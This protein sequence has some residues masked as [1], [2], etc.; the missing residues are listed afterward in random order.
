MIQQ[1][2]LKCLLAVGFMTAAMLSAFGADNA[3]DEAVKKDRKRIEGTWKVVSFTINGN[4]S[5]GDIGKIIVVNGADGSWNLTV[6][7]QELGQGATTINP[8]KKPKEIDI[9]PTTGDDKGKVYPGIY[10]VA[11]DT[12]KLCFA[13]TGK[14]R[15]TEFTSVAGTDHVLVMFERVKK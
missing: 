8:S 4:A 11:D 12:R 13:P 2:K 5:T 3:D 14:P 9:T 15:P 1:S 6:N 7:D 10:E